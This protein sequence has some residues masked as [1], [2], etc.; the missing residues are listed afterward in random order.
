MQDILGVKRKV[1][2]SYH[3]AGAQQYCDMLG[4]LISDVFNI[5]TDRSLERAVDSNVP[6]YVMRRISE[7]HIK[8]TSCTIVLVGT[9]SSNRK[10]IDREIKA[11]L[12]KHHGLLGINLPEN[13]IDQLR[14]SA[15]KPYRLQDNIDSGDAVW[16]LW[17]QVTNNP[18]YLNSLIEQAISSPVYKINNSRV[19]MTRNT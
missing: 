4:E 16:K 2:I 6:E 12:D 15:A 17:S 13:P 8:G 19:M 14:N 1:F 10:Y 7:K 3:H 5:A 18:Q 9:E 11:T